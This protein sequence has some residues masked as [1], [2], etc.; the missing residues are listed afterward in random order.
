ML[1]GQRTWIVDPERRAGTDFTDLPPAIAASSPGDTI[2]VRA[3]GARVSLAA[4]TNKGLTILGEG[5]A[6][7][8]VGTLSV[9]DV[10]TGERFVIRDLGTAVGGGTSISTIRLDNC[11]GS[12]HVQ[13]V[14]IWYPY[15]F[16]SAS[17]FTMEVAGCSG[18][19]LRRCWTGGY[20]TS[21]R[22]VSSS[23]VAIDC[24]FDGDLFW[25]CSR[26]CQRNASIAAS[27]SNSELLAVDCIFRGGNGWVNYLCNQGQQ[28][29]V[30]ISLAGSR[31]T[32][33]GSSSAV[34]GGRTRDS[35][36]CIFGLQPAPSIVGDGNVVADPSAEIDPPPLL[37][38]FRWP[39]P[40]T[41]ASLAAFGGNLQ[42]DVNGPSL[43]VAAT[44]VSLPGP[45]VPTSFGVLWLDSTTLASVD[46]GMTDGSG[47]R[48]V[49][50]QSLTVPNGVP[51]LF[52]TLLLSGSLLSLTVPAVMVVGP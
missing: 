5:A 37:H 23:V 41:R 4:S 8:L 44:F 17:T 13:N 32:L 2:Q 12:V 29:Q 38:V 21:F 16:G 39:E 31:L 40:V 14:G 9:H 10:P 33:A 49:Q 50:V 19:T 35:S 6:H 30:G 47:R 42:V 36:V 28:N 27:I 1:A 11:R 48:T 25:D 45:A 43:A 20:A 3:S 51:L 46:L 26:I 15:Q 52:Q 22:V 18:V 24:R 7:S 34:T